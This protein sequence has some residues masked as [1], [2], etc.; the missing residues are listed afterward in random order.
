MMQGFQDTLLKGRTKNWTILTLTPLEFTSILS[1]ILLNG[2]PTALKMLQ[3][4]HSRLKKVTFFWTHP[5]SSVYLQI[6]VHTQQYLGSACHFLHI[7][8]LGWLGQRQKTFVNRKKFS[9]KY[10]RIELI[11]KWSVRLS[12]SHSFQVQGWLCHTA[13]KQGT[14]RTTFNSYLGIIRNPVCFNH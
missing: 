14:T 6:F 10:P 4:K 5:V 12:S 13:V 3:R 7:D 9:N 2:N 8:P 11:I 1:Q